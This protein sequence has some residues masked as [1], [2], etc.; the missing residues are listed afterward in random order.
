MSQFARG[1]ERV[2][3]DPDAVPVPSGML[4]RVALRVFD[5][6]RAY[7]TVSLG[8]L[9]LVLHTLRGRGLHV[10]ADRLTT[11]AQPL[12]D[13]TGARGVLDLAATLGKRN[14]K[15]TK[16]IAGSIRSD[17][18]E[19]A[20][21]NAFH[22]LGWE[23]FL[24]MLATWS[25]NANRAVDGVELSADGAVARRDLILDLARRVREV[26]AAWEAVPETWTVT[27]MPVDGRTLKAASKVIGLSVD[28]TPSSTSAVDMTARH[29]NRIGRALAALALS[30]AP[31]SLTNHAP[32][33]LVRRALVVL[34]VVA[35][36]VTLRSTEARLSSHC[37]R[38]PPAG[39][40]V[41]PN[42]W[43]SSSWWPVL[44]AWGSQSRHVQGM[45]K[46]SWRLPP[47]DADVAVWA[48]GYATALVGTCA[49]LRPGRVTE[50]QWDDHV[51]MTLDPIWGLRVE[52]VW[53]LF[54]ST[55]LTST[56]APFPSSYGSVCAFSR[57]DFGNP[58]TL[59][60]IP[61][62]DES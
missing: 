60:W 4:R 18:L 50:R 39:S 17:E 55:R 11:A 49:D 19:S 37:L 43:W 41:V 14:G 28:G 32:A 12:V 15:P 6:P 34:T 22:A 59:P 25:P 9:D 57:V 13:A 31:A 7:T 27:T 46:T 42:S 23:E 33:W 53:D 61:G 16:T 26:E 20:L 24:P 44:D 56:R 29:S 40:P 47:A 1:S 3:Q 58:Q 62:R 54:Q 2:D 36:A 30:K 21:A 48:I 8:G 38:V 45:V 5:K 51:L 35:E 52:S 10:D